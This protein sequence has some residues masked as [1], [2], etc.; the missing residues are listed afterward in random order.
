MQKQEALP[1]DDRVV[2]A[3]LAPADDPTVVFKAPPKAAEPK[4]GEDERVDFDKAAAR[5]QKLKQAGP[6]KGGDCD[7]AASA[8]RRVA[9]R[10]PGLLIARHN[11]AAVGFECGRQQDA[12]RI[13]EDLANKGYA[14]ALGQLGY[15]AWQAGD[16]GRAEGYFGRAI[17]ADPQVAS[18]AARMNLAQILR[19]RARRMGGSEKD[20]LAREAST[21]LRTVLALDGNNL[22][23]YATLCH[24]YYDIRL[25]DAAILVGRQGLKRAEEIA[26]GKFEDQEAVQEAGAEPDAAAKRRGKRPQEERGASGRRRAKEVGGTGWTV[27]MK[28][29][30][31]FVYNTL[32]LVDLDRK[33]FSEAIAHFKVAVKQDPELY[34]A[35]L[36]LA[37]LSLKF[38][39]Y[40]TADENFG[41]VL[42]AQPRN[43]EAMMGRGVALRGNRK[44]DEAEQVYAN[45]Q[46]VDPSRPESYFNLGLL[47]QEYKGSERAMLQKAQEYYRQFLGRAGG[48]TSAALKRDAQKRIKDIDELYVALEEAAKLQR[49]AEQQQRLQQE[50]DKKRE[51]D[52]RKQEEAEKKAAAAGGGAGGAA[53][54]PPSAP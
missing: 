6:L 35:R 25:P 14:P 33:R 31:A 21:H 54:S 41:A 22:Q 46:Q 26:T 28:K 9:D 44:F 32:G 49:E 52:I 13:W 53:V 11:E 12:M 48:G 19:E 1:E 43:Y 10:S 20:R 30:T 27:E 18:I 2:T 29:H 24:L 37:A 23:A 34:E 38:R 36:N 39:D 50:Q 5:Y 8:F 3:A 45:A 7:D 42:A 47:H 16:A 4:V 51:E 15:A 17:A 40:T